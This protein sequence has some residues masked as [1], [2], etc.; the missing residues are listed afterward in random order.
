MEALLEHFQIGIADIPVL[1]CRDRDRALRNP[2]NAEVAAVLG[3]NSELD[4]GHVHDL[5]VVG[6]GPP[7]SRRPS[8][9]HRKGST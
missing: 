1:M 3:F 8:M 5:V 4:D 9:R 7:G 6:A 2:S